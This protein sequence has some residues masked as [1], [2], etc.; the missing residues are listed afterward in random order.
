MCDKEEGVMAKILCFAMLVF[1]SLGV[2]LAGA[3]DAALF[4]AARKEGLV[5][6]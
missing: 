6:W 1:F 2:S 4:Q 3:Q 5:I